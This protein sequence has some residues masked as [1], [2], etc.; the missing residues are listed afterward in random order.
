M[1]EL[2]VINLL[3]TAE[4]GP[5]SPD[6]LR[7]RR[8]REAEKRFDKEAPPSVQ[9]KARGWGKQE[10]VLALAAVLAIMFLIRLVQP[11]R[12]GFLSLQPCHPRSLLQQTHHL[13]ST[14]SC[15]VCSYFHLV[16]RWTVLIVPAVRSLPQLICMLTIHFLC[17]Y[18]H[19]CTT[20]LCIIAKQVFTPEELATYDGRQRRQLY[21]A[22][23][24]EV[25]DVSAPGGQKQYGAACLS[26]IVG[27]DCVTETSTYL[28]FHIFRIKYSWL[29]QPETM[30]LRQ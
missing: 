6:G 17:M 5:L 14:L 20:N 28:N 10:A 21:L 12:V 24:G 26:C 3:A 30:R 4:D 1:E 16:A 2:Y 18:V 22:V 8:I 19:H 15:Y 13:P 9:L 23:L 29:R 27:S 11:G 25:Y 7:R